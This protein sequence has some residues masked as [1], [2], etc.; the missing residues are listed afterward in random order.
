M[1]WQQ[2]LYFPIQKIRY[3][4]SWAKIRTEDRGCVFRE[5]ESYIILQHV[6]LRNR[7]SNKH[8]WGIST[9]SWALG[10]SGWYAD[11]KVL[12]A[13]HRPRWHGHPTKHLWPGLKFS[14]TFRYLTITN[15][16]LMTY[17]RWWSK[18]SPNEILYLRR[19]FDRCNT[20]SR[21]SY[22]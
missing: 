21:R 4:P 9:N 14:R 1:L 13:K 12:Y 19:P 16:L 10:P 15:P 20:F 3:S 11:M 2:G 18:C 22:I 8:N 17:F 5:W 7:G 6:I